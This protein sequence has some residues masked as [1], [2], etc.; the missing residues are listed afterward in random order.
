MKRCPK[1][2]KCGHMCIGYCGDVCPNLCRVCNKYDIE[3]TSLM[4]GYDVD[5]NTR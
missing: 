5:E 1:K 3:E 4:F 2:L